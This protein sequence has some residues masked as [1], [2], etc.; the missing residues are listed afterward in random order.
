MLDAFVAEWSRQS[1]TARAEFEMLGMNEQH[2]EWRYE[3]NHSILIRVAD[4]LGLDY[5]RIPWT[6]R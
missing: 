1:R 2:P 6:E 3:I 4:A 5:R